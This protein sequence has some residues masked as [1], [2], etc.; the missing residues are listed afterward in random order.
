MVSYI[1]MISPAFLLM[2]VL[3]FVYSRIHWLPA[4]ISTFSSLQ[5]VIVAVVANATLSIGKTS[6]ST[7]PTHR[8]NSNLEQETMTRNEMRFSVDALLFAD[9]S[10]KD[11]ANR[12]TP[13]SETLV[14]Q[15]F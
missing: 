6:L 14:I 12:R 1:G 8:L 2:L 5:A 10:K 7:N 13:T 11:P 9:C 4:L 15:F 3:S